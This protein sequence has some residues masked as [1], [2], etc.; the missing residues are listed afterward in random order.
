M[1]HTF[2]EFCPGD[3]THLLRVDTVAIIGEVGGDSADSGS[4]N[5]ASGDE[6]VRWTG[7]LSQSIRVLRK[8]RGWSQRALARRAGL[9]PDTVSQLEAGS[10][11]DISLQTLA[12]LQ[13]ALDLASLEQLLGGF[14]KFPSKDWGDRISSPPSTDE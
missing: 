12:R 8:S 11:T 7:Q 4:D 13:L 14:S 9:S 2:D 3:R 5:V 6:G 1:E 10:R